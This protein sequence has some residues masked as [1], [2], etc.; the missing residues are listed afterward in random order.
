MVDPVWSWTAFIL[1]AV[2][3]GILLNGVR[4]YGATGQDVPAAKRM[5]FAGFVLAAPLSLSLIIHVNTE[6]AKTTEFCG[7]CHLMAPKVR[8]LANADSEH[9]ASMHAHRGWIQTNSCYVCHTDYHM[10]GGVTAKVRGMRHLYAQLFR[11]LEEGELGLYRPY[12][13]ANCLQCHAGKRRFEE[14]PLHADIL[15]ELAADRVSC[16]SCHD[17]IHPKK[18]GDS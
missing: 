18:G 7:S 11:K 12:P 17:M 10:F 6:Q 16:V 15:Q 3:A 14:F 2:V 4:R 5:L 13:N 9:L 8:D 1:A